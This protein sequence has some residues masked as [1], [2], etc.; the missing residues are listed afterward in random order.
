MEDKIATLLQTTGF[1]RYVFNTPT[2]PLAK[3]PVPPPEANY[4]NV[5]FAQIP[6]WEYPLHNYQDYSIRPFRW[7]ENTRAYNYS[8]SQPYFPSMPNK[9]QMK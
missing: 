9:N 5:R 8:H 2:K 3:L 1:S 7:A 6:R 4:Q